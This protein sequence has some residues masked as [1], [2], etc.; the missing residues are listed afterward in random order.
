MEGLLRQMPEADQR[1]I[2]EMVRVE[3][4]YHSQLGKTSSKPGKRAG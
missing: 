2:L 4:K 1:R 3:H